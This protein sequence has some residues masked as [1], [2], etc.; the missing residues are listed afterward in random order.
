[1]N[2]IAPHITDLRKQEL[3]DFLGIS[4]FETLNLDT[5][6]TAFA[7]AII[8]FKDGTLLLE[9]LSWLGESFFHGVGK[10]HQESDL[11][12]VA[13]SA[14]ELAFAVRTP[15]VYFNIEMYLS[16]IDAFSKAHYRD[17]PN[18]GNSN[19]KQTASPSKDTEYTI[20]AWD[21]TSGKKKR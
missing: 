6:N 5:G 13:L 21:E 18:N 14:A 19:D 20:H 4:D 17:E 16:D 15:A 12:N 2:T 8:L 1:V 11:F 3:K 9:E 7:E 10:H